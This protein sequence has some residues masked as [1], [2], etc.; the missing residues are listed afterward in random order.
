[1]LLL[2]EP[3]LLALSITAAVAFYIVNSFFAKKISKTD[4]D[5][6]IYLMVQGVVCAII[7]VAASGGLGSISWYS[8]IFGVIFGVVTVCQ[9]LFNL[10][11]LAIG[12]FSYTS[13][14]VSLSTI[15]PTLSGL[16]WGEKIGTMQMI[17]IVLMVICILMST[18]KST[19]NKKVTTKWLVFCLLASVF[20][21][22]M[23]I[24][25]KM[26]QTSI[27]KDES[28]VFLCSTMITLAIF[29]AFM[30]VLKMKQ[31][32]GKPEGKITL[33]LKPSHIIIPLLAGVSYALCHVINLNLSGRVPAAVLF[34]LINISPLVLTTVVATIMY[35]E[36]L[37][38][39]R[40]IGIAIGILSTF[41]VSGVLSTLLGI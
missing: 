14:I 9:L 31:N 21:G 28:P 7:A 1:M 2:P 6:Y 30:L 34:P 11:A 27:H 26:H 35:K 25:Q 5:Y 16:F 22:L 29:S 10:K 41:F 8:I 4:P 39:K 24:I 18:D 23:G 36:R 33:R 19:E 13:V 20:N 32:T 38:T 15:I 12:P 3:T 17:G 37:S 40:W